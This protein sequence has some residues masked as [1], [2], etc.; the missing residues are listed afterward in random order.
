[1]SGYPIRPD[2][3]V[4]VAANTYSRYQGGALVQQ[5]RRR[6]VPSFAAHPSPNSN[7]MHV[8]EPNG[9]PVTPFPIVY[10]VSGGVA[11]WAGDVNYPPSTTHNPIHRPNKPT[12]NSPLLEPQQP[13]PVNGGTPH[14]PER[15][16]R[17]Q[18][19]V[20]TNSARA[21]SATPPQPRR[22]VKT[23]R[24][25]QES[26]KRA[27]VSKHTTLATLVSSDSDIKSTASVTRHSNK[28]GLLY[29]R[30][31]QKSKSPMILPSGTHDTIAGSQAL[32]RSVSGGV[33]AKASAVPNG[34]SD[35]N[36][37][38]RMPEVR[39]SST[40]GNPTQA[41]QAQPFVKGTARPKATDT[42]QPRTNNT[43]QPRTKDKAQP[44]NT[45]GSRTRDTKPTHQSAP[46]A[47]KY[48]KKKSTQALKNK[49]RTALLEEAK[50][51]PLAP[52]S[53]RAPERITSKRLITLSST[54]GN[55]ASMNSKS[56]RKTANM[57]IS[58]PQNA[59]RATDTVSSASAP[60]A[61]TSSPQ[62][63]ARK[64]SNKACS[65]KLTKM[66]SDKL[67]KSHK[68]PKSSKSP[69]SP[70][71][72]VMSTRLAS[73]KR[74]RPMTVQPCGPADGSSG[75]CLQEPLQREKSSSTKDYSS[76]AQLVKLQ[77]SIVDSKP[78]QAA[79]NDDKADHRRVTP[80]GGAR[81]RK[82]LDST[83][84]SS[85][86]TKRSTKGRNSAHSSVQKVKPHFR[87]RHVK[88]KSGGGKNGHG[89]NAHGKGGLASKSRRKKLRLAAHES[90]SMR[91]TGFEDTWDSILGW[92][93]VN[94]QGLLMLSALILT[95]V[96]IC[97]HQPASGEN[98]SLVEALGS[99]SSKLASEQRQLQEELQIYSKENHYLREWMR[100]MHSEL[101]Y[102]SGQY[103]EAHTAENLQLL[104]PGANTPQAAN[105]HAV[106][107]AYT[108]AIPVG[109]A[110]GQEF[111]V[112]VNNVIY[113]V[114]CPPNGSPGD[115][116]AFD[117]PKPN[118]FTDTERGT[119]LR[120]KVIGTRRGQEPPEEGVPILLSTLKSNTL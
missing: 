96:L 52:K 87:K 26:S 36:T 81:D 42:A 119:P 105:L 95:G 101:M 59:M 72:T 120:D 29:Q 12:N 66:F 69:N 86:S 45:A 65:L 21:P 77:T 56:T 112:D 104:P 49:P 46:S 40:P 117:V 11:F 14:G 98:E 64:P 102:T 116:I 57:P 44:G 25:K 18:G 5:W 76:Q 70:K 106:R 27:T 115:T 107:Q 80:T 8:Y 55:S 109:I 92:V 31:N 15:T 30:I 39:P 61:C 100:Q 82:S 79:K 78:V 34:R 53:N 93:E 22:A 6:S 97:L 84:Q 91:L 110:G 88:G 43:A 9:A 4:M 63:S 90:R 35:R 108:V 74:R 99:H 94:Q 54:P 51:Y 1:M 23:K 83:D 32:Q 103:R 85:R 33:L 118:I 17:P 111:E 2:D 113:I 7:G 28:S 41:K 13:N 10:I 68:S 24:K 37:E 16:S 89:G 62:A 73:E 50:G 67:A 75:T 38:P 60:V 19:P 47:A 3:R 71:T 48:T 20:A 58:R 114:K